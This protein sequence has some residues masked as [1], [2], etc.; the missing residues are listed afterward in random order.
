MTGFTADFKL[1]ESVG[2]CIVTDL[3]LVPLTALMQLR[4]KEEIH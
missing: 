2:L 3:Q 4:H 1:C